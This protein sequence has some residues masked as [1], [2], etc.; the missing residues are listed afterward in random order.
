MDVWLGYGHI[1][2]GGVASTKI[3]AYVS[4]VKYAAVIARTET[5]EKIWVG[6]DLM[7]VSPGFNPSWKNFKNTRKFQNP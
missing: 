1:V 7:P 5:A 2:L 4:F 3:G 6:L